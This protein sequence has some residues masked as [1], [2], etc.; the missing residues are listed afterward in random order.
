MKFKKI[1]KR[2]FQINADSDPMKEHFITLDSF[3]MK[4]FCSSYY[5]LETFSLERLDA[6]E[7]FII[8]T[9][10]WMKKE[11]LKLTNTK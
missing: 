3:S 10:L 6:I 2:I 7:I 8:H 5:F 1:L 11:I 9:F 4:D